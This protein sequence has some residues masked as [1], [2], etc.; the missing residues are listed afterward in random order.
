MPQA[1]LAAE[2]VAARGPYSGAHRM[3][4]EPALTLRRENRSPRALRQLWQVP[5]FVAGVLALLVVA[6]LHPLGSQRSERQL[7]R[8]LASARHALEQPKP[9]LDRVRASLQQA[10][11]QLPP[12]SRQAGEAHFLL[13][14]ALLL[15]AERSP[16]NA[17]AS[18]WQQAR[19][20]FEQADT[21][22][23]PDADRPRLA[24]RLG[25]TYHALN[26]DPQRVVACLSWSVADGADNP[27]DGYALLAQ[28]Y[29][30]LPTPDLRN[31]LEATRKQLAL[32]NADE[33]Q[34]ATPRLLCGELLCKLEQLDEARKMLARI[35]TGAPPEML[36]RARLLR[37]K[38]SQEEGSW[39]EAAKLW[40]EVRQ[41]PHWQD[42]EPGR[43]LYYLGVCY[44][45][46]DQ[47]EK[48]LK[49]WEECRQRNADEGRAAALEVAQLR[50]RGDQPALALEAFSSA[51]RGVATPADYRNS[52]I[53]LAEARNRFETGCQVYRQ[54]GAYEAAQQLARLYERIALPG[55]GQELAGQAAAAWA[56]SLLEQVPRAVTDQAARALEEEARLHFRE[57]GMSYERAADLSPSGAEQ[58]DWLWHSAGDY[59]DGQERDR[60]VRVLER[61]VQLPNAPADRLGQAWFL[62]GEAHRLLHND[63]MAQAA[64][65]KCIEY[66]GAYAY[67]ARYELAIAR[68]EQ[69]NYDDAE[70]ELKHNLSLAPPGSEAHE[71]SLVTLAT[72]QFQQRDY[73]NAFLN[74]Q[75][76]LDTYPA[77][78]DAP[79]LRLCYAQCCRQ[80]AEQNGNRINDGT[81]TTPEE[82]MFRQKERSKWLEKAAL[83]Y[84][85]LAQ[86]LESVAA[87]R[88]LGAEELGVLRQSHFAYAEC[89]FDLGKFDEALRLYNALADRYHGQLDELIALRHVWQCHGVLFQP[90]QSRT[91]LDRIR[92]AMK[93][94]PPTAFDGASDVA[95]RAWWENWLAEKS[96]LRDVAKPPVRGGAP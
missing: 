23:T 4:T 66:P 22:G 42:A 45:K 18:L 77:N 81:Y 79:R 13:G 85:K 20:H 15:Q 67:R 74:L 89:R 51:L 30:R 65:Q 59:L 60:A 75:K 17:S 91:T 6:C 44:R 52:L 12:Q 73:S 16:T 25:K 26:G 37:A 11:A 88:S 34:L 83:Q 86:D 90:D 10:L 27:F 47:P 21:L 46:L 62:L 57:A 29:L 54:I 76:A 93:D 3:S 95:T 5:T 8:D 56:R 64:Y 84:Q 38:L 40:E 43:T 96:K 71:K 70:A 50:L 55:V 58:A 36:F 32:P 41:D 69:K 39:A 78:P 28:A 33:A 9:D 87:N 1:A 72:L 63:V 19:E 92:T 14:S 2:Q 61:F 80:L 82:L 49:V 24:F 94:L 68:I 53:D 7:E 48:A 31:A 35:G